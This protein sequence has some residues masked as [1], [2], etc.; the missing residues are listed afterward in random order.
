VVILTALVL[1]LWGGAI[2]FETPMLF[3]VAFLPMFGLGGLTGLPLGFSTTDIHLHDTYYVVGHFHLV[4]APG[5]LFAIFAGIYHWFPKVTGRTLSEGLGKLHFWPSLLFMNGIFLPMLIQGLA[6]V[7]RRLY[8]GGATY[9]HAQ[10]VLELN[11]FI[12][13]C[14]AGLAVAQLPFLLNL[15]LTLR[16]PRPEPAP[17][18][19]AHGPVPFTGEP[20]RDTGLSNTQLGMGLFLASE[21]M[22]FGALVASY[23]LLRLGAEPGSWPVEGSWTSLPL[24]LVNTGILLAATV[25]TVRASRAVRRGREKAGQRLLGLATAGSA[26]F[27]AIKG[28][29]WFSKLEEGLNPAHHIFLA[30]YFAL[31]GIHALH[32]LGGIGWNLQSLRGPLRASRFQA[33]A[34]YAVF[35]DGVWWGLFWIFYLA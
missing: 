6:G 20:R 22:L 28:W 21:A 30:L 25:L 35:V 26:L 15:L 5:T 14:A 8:D 27:L 10:G 23:L 2:R 31:T 17:A 16:R 32:V 3:A 29:E 11:P 24:G 1:S 4:V 7:S 34:W 13:Y 12:L 18:A 33:A 9:R 19:A